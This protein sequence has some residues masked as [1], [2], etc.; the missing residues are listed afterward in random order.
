MTVQY[1]PLN[2]TIHCTDMMQCM[3]DTDR[4]ICE[5][6]CDKCGMGN[7]FRLEGFFVSMLK[8]YGESTCQMG[9]KI[10]RTKDETCDV[11]KAGGELLAKAVEAPQVIP[12]EMTEA[13]PDAQSILK[14]LNGALDSEDMTLINTTALDVLKDKMNS[15]D[16][17]KPFSMGCSISSD[18]AD[19][20]GK[21][22]E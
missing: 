1:D 17:L 3:Q 6:R 2:C 10:Y 16:K 8:Q 11:C 4:I 21:P 19:E 9:R 15:F 7:R 14:S 22:N 5:I 12:V 18:K 20:L 13:P